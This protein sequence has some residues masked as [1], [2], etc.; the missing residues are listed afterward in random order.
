MPHKKK[1]FSRATVIY[2]CLFAIILGKIIRY[3]LMKEVQV[4]Q[5]IGWSFVKYITND[6]PLK[7]GFTIKNSGVSEIIMAE[8][9]TISFFKLINIFNLQNYYQFEIFISI[10]W[11]IL[12]IIMVWKEKKT[13]DFKETIFILASIAA[14]N[15][16][17]F[18]LSKEPVQ[19]IYFILMYLVLKSK[20]CKN[21]IFLICSFIYVLSALTFRNYYILMFYFMVFLK[22]YFEKVIYINGKV[23]L[24]DILFLLI[25]ILLSYFLLLSAIKIISTESYNE[26]IRVRLRTSTATTDIRSIFNSNNLFIFSI[27]YLLVIVRLLIPI[28]LIRFGLKYFIYIV[29]QLIITSL[30]VNKTK[31]LRKLSNKEKVIIYILYAFIFGSA[32]FEPDFGSWIRHETVVF[33]L[34]LILLNTCTNEGV[35]ENVEI[36]NSAR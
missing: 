32:A 23:K 14:L 19:M 25:L 29:Y 31:Q 36:Y 13:Y 8:D 6:L 16:F 10:L 1:R 34:L 17:S 35:K 3:T 28:E 18:C 15:L 33:P 24:K 5:G 27:D 2:F 7:F 4:Y 9:N 26:L 21:S 11:N 30:L 22:N 20:K 12:T